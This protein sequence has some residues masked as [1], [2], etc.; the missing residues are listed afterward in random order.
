[1]HTVG[2]VV[3]EDYVTDDYVVIKDPLQSLPSLVVVERGAAA[4][5]E[6]GGS[7][8]CVIDGHVSDDYITDDHISDD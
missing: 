5:W 4:P 6:T 8:D 3:V 1:V 2:S 7:D